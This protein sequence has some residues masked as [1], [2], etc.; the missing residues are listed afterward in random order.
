[1]VD[2]ETGIPELQ[3]RLQEAGID[4]IV[5]EVQSQ[6]DAWLASNAS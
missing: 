5:A 4:A 1:L 2:P 3:A 6:Y